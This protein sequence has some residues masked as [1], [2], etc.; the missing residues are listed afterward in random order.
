MEPEH[1]YDRYLRFS[2]LRTAS[3]VGG[4]YLTS[5]SVIG[6]ARAGNADSGG[7]GVGLCGYVRKETHLTSRDR[8][9]LLKPS[10]GEEHI[11]VSAAPELT[12]FIPPRISIPRSVSVQ[13]REED[14]I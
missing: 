3:L 5:T 11:F 14:A 2:A 10:F 13:M 9:L 1:I 6:R 12:G 7:G 8:L 4:V